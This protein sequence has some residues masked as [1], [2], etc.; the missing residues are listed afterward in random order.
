[1]SGW[2]LWFRH[3]PIPAKLK[4]ITHLLVL[5]ALLPIISINIGYEYLSVR[6]SMRS[7]AEVRAN[8]IRENV[9]A[10]TA[11]GDRESADETL[12]SLRAS[13]N[14]IQAVLLLRDG[15]PLARFSV[16]G[17]PERWM[18]IPNRTDQTILGW[19]RILVARSVYLKESRVGWL[20][21]ETSMKP[22]HDRL[23][24]YALVSLVAVLISIALTSMLSRRLT[25]GITTPLSDLMDL[26]RHVTD[27][28]DYSPP[29]R[30]S[31]SQD[32][33]GGL[34]RAFDTMLAAIR[35]RDARLSQIAYCDSLT[36]LANRH[37]FMERLQQSVDQARR[38]GKSCCLMFLDLDHFKF[39]N[40]TYGHAVGDALLREVARRLKNVMRNDDFIGRLGGD[41]F[42][43]IIENAA[44]GAGL[45][46]ASGKLVRSLS[47]PMRIEECDVQI[48]ASIGFGR[49]PDDADKVSEL[50]RMADVAMYAAKKGGKNR[51]RAYSPDLEQDERR[52]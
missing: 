15:T 31:D 19:N 48:G 42:A 27:H 52:S 8:I 39:V 49:C 1:M 11:F 22:L 38:S 14:V 32:E 20:M 37:A 7:E 5:L 23:L 29:L 40:D 16:G 41:E 9:A 51:F 18:E 4:L 3:R 17:E 2:A 35:E 36:G 12:S 45:A 30:V 25:H 47:E 44:D 28:Q 21:I 43:I 46:I 26:A 13:P 10:A 34:S 33:I 50:M 6:D 24:L